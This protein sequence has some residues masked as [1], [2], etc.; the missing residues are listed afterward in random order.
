MGQDRVTECYIIRVNLVT[1]S[2]GS[3]GT[4]RDSPITTVIIA[5]VGSDDNKLCNFL[6]NRNV[7]KYCHQLFSHFISSTSTLFSGN[8]IQE[9]R[10]KIKKDIRG[11]FP[12]LLLCLRLLLG[13]HLAVGNPDYTHSDTPTN[14]GMVP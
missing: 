4:L 8:F 13:S 14:A 6:G 11:H 5:N 1:G 3:S 12:C 2:I 10:S 7:E 9:L